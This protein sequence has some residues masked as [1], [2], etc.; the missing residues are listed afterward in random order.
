MQSA[1]TVV[2]VTP[3]EARR[4]ARRKAA[5]KIYS[6]AEKKW[7]PVGPWGLDKLAQLPIF[8]R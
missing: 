7:G 5:P 1:V 6:D 4:L 3:D 2:R 8:V